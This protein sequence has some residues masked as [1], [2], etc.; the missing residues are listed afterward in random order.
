MIRSLMFVLAGMLI[1]SAQS[2][3]QTKIAN[4]PPFPK[5]FQ[6]WQKEGE[7]TCTT[8]SGLT[9]KESMHVGV[10]DKGD[11]R[12]IM[13][14]TANGRLLGYFDSPL[15]GMR[16]AGGTAYIKTKKSG[17]VSYDLSDEAR[18]DA[19]LDRVIRESGMTEND[20]AECETK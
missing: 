11:M 7:A 16:V 5:D 13:I 12:A 8:R 10:G 17:W 3:A 1:F 4:P 19:A 14:F 9:I 18:K 2:F 6:Q 20:L 15:N